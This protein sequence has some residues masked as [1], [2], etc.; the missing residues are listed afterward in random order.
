MVEIV[1]SIENN[2]IETKNYIFFDNNIED[3]KVCII[4]FENN[5]IKILCEKCKYKYC[6]NCSVKLNNNCSI[7][8]RNKKKN[9]IYH[10]DSNNYPYI[11]YDYNE[12]Y[13]YLPMQYTISVVINTI[14]GI[15]HIIMVLF[16]GY[17]IILFVIN[18]LSNILGF[19]H[20]LKFTQLK[21]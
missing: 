17:I 10:V 14:V 18:I 8:F 19:L 7:C 20:H 1:E 3:D 15:F 4:C 5:G 9:I 6:Q 12:E 13:V 16:F 2:N 11:Y 21:I